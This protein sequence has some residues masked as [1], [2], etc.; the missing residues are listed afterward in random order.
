MLLHLAILHLWREKNNPDFRILALA[1]W[2][3]VF[4][5][6]T[7]S[8]LT[9][10]LRATLLGE[11][12]ELL[13]ADLIVE[14]S[15]PLDPAL[16]QFAQEQGLRTSFMVEFYSMVMVNDKMQLASI[17]VF[18]SS[19]PLRGELIISS[20]DTSQV[21]LAPPPVGEIWIEEDLALKLNAKQNAAVT[22]GYAK[23]KMTGI[24]HQRPLAVSDSSALASVA[25]VNALDLVTMGVLQP[26]SRATYRLLV[27]GNDKQLQRF[28]DHFKETSPDVNW[29]T[30]QEGR[31]ALTRTISYGKRYLA[32]ILLIQVLL[33]GTAIAICAHQY[34]LRQQKTV[35]IWRCLGASS[36]TIVGLHILIL[37]ILSAVVLAFSIV[38][39]Y[40]VAG[41]ILYY[42]QRLGFY[43]T[44]LG[45]QGALLGALTGV[46]MLLGFAIPPLLR[47][48]HIPP[49]QIIQQQRVVLFDAVKSY[50]FAFL[51]LGILFASFLG[52]HDVAIRLGAQILCLGLVTFVLAYGLWYCFEPLCRIGP[53]PWRFGVSY[54]VRHKWQGIT[55]WLVFTMVMSLLILVQIVQ[56]DFI[57]LWQGQIPAF[58]P[59][60]FLLNIQEEKI[61][62]LK[63]W[64][65]RQDIKNVQFYPI[66]RARM[67]HVNGLS[68]FGPNKL[69]TSSGLDRPINLT[70]MRQFPS[71]NKVI[72]GKKWEEV[73]DGQSL[74][75]VEA[76]FA[77]RQHLKLNDTITFQIAQDFITGTI[78][79]FRTVEWETFKP[80][81]F[82][83][84]PPK[85]I[86]QFP[87]SYIT[88]FYLPPEKKPLLVP[89]IQK[90]VETS[91]LDIDAFLH[92]AR[93]LI[94]KISFAL[95]VLL[96]L[97]FI[98]GVVIMY[99]SLLSTL[100]ERLQESAMLQIL[101]ANKRLVAKVLL[102][103]FS[104]LGVFS[105][106][107]ASSMA[108]ALAHDLAHNIF[109]LPFGLD[110]TW[111]IVGIVMSTIMIAV[112]GLVGA[113]AVFRV[114]P[115]WLL[116]QTT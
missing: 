96:G 52:E 90:N 81:F 77:N 51:A 50:V 61:I 7:L 11:A 84:F 40:L 73:L 75:S 82:V 41:S 13:G 53:L 16:L 111:M 18:D 67:S 21:K 115:L 55:Q 110:F 10:S 27:A 83:I 100:K 24:I 37:L 14:S 19:F 99:A 56:H 78:V 54:M 5:V 59:N 88:S 44:Q 85:V 70:W 17:N 108:L 36:R 101:G 12:S 60:Y 116:R 105:G 71:D 91:L 109:S 64:F 114:S 79:Q 97:V 72:S 26:G 33:A 22:I 4:A 86:D 38:S 94:A 58:T 23:L 63:E 69:S 47:L 87:H 1:L 48:R 2:L 29:I 74:I 76:S 106:V 68:L 20:N 113:R 28:R 98:L 112:F 9:Q 95:E 8:C 104:V 102:I 80:N 15:L 65:E 35:A 46:V 25:Y 49:I 107:V 43:A 3:A 57:N 93:Q 32:I 62:S 66:V 42:A 103:E 34:S 39:G 89:L 31:S 45:G 30:P 92:K 6:T